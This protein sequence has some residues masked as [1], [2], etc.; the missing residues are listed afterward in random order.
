MEYYL[1]ISQILATYVITCVLL[2]SD[3]AWGSLARLRNNESVKCFGLLDCFLCL[4]FWVALIVTVV[5]NNAWA[6]FFIIWG[7]AY[8]IDQLIMA[9]KTR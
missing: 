2:Y 9:Y 8:I 5:S 7:T 6:E 3:G 4:S 1:I